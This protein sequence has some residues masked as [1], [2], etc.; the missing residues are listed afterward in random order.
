MSDLFDD[1][2]VDEDEYYAN[3]GPVSRYEKGH[4]HSR[5]PEGE[6]DEYD[7][8]NKDIVSNNQKGRGTAI[9]EKSKSSDED[10][11]DDTDR[12]SMDDVSGSASNSFGVSDWL[13]LLVV[14]AIGF[15]VVSSDIFVNQ[16]LVHVPNA[17]AD[18][19]PTVWGSLV[20]MICQLLIVVISM[21]AKK[22]W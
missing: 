15:M 20:Q 7:E 16:V 12:E 6:Y 19:E 2:Y 22:N 13:F 1:E 21:I 14:I 11:V 18:D 17:V 4:H 8:Y 5:D 9:L 3:K 10:I